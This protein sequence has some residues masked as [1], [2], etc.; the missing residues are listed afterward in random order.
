MKFSSRRRHG[1]Q[2]LAGP[3]DGAHARPFF[4]TRDDISET[5]IVGV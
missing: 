4:R 5:E 1:A 2:A 3:V